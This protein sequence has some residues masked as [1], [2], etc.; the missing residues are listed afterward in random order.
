MENPGRNWPALLVEEVVLGVKNTKNKELRFHRAQYQRGD[1]GTGRELERF[2][3]DPS[4]SAAHECE[5]TI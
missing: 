4:Y 2:W 5:E 3:G 1:N